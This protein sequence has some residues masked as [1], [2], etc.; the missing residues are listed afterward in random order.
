MKNHETSHTCN[1]DFITFFASKSL[2]YIINAIK[3]VFKAFIKLKECTNTKLLFISDL[4]TFIK[5]L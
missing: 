5:L 4:G 3:N 1:L 2:C